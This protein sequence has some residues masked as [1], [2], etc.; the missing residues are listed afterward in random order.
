MVQPG[1]VGPG[2]HGTAH[3][4]NGFGHAAKAQKRIDERFGAHGIGGC[5]GESALPAGQRPLGLAEGGE[6]VAAGTLNFRL[7]GETR[8][9][10]AVAVGE[11]GR[12]FLA[13]VCCGG[14]QAM[15][16]FQCLRPRWRRRIRG[17][18]DGWLE[19]GRGDEQMAQN[20]CAPPALRPSADAGLTKLGPKSIHPAKR[21]LDGASRPFKMFALTA[22]EQTLLA[23]LLA[24][25]V[26]GAAVKHWRD[27]RRE[28]RPATAAGAA[29]AAVIER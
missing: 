19:P 10:V 8:G 23:V 15:N 5:Q 6:G 12:R 28:G 7:V 9:Q 16:F 25:A 1:V 3:G 27:A 4:R 29:T 24:A 14:F 21:N 11:T 18:G 13:L 22:R 20:R 26:L 2:G 17:F